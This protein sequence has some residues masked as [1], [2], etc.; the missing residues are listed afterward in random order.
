MTVIEGGDIKYA[1]F[2]SKNP[3]LNQNG[4]KINVLLPVNIFNF[5]G[6]NAT[7]EGNLETQLGN[8]DDVS[9]KLASGNGPEEA[10]AAPFKLNI[11]LTDGTAAAVS[12][13]NNAVRQDSAPP[14]GYLVPVLAVFASVSLLAMA[15]MAIITIRKRRAHGK[16]GNY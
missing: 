9:R 10:A 16:N 12:E 15:G 2:S 3:Y 6:S 14:S 11:A 7:V 8:G 13:I 4:Y 1:S 5:S